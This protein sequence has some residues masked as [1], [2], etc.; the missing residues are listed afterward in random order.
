MRVGRTVRG[1][2]GRERWERS[3]LDKIVE[4]LW[5]TNEDDSEMDGEKLKGEAVMMDKDCKAK[6]EGEE[7][8]P[9]PKRAHIT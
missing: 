2:P 4:V 1:K 3:N 6:L 8:V 5:R 7:H 9:V